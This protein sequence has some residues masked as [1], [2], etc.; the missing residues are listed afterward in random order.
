MT[1][2]SAEGTRTR[3]LGR[4]V[5]HHQLAIGGM[6]AVYLGKLLGPAGFSRAVAIK[7]LHPHLAH[8]PQFSQMLLDEARIAARIR[9][10]NVVPTLDVV[11]EGGE[12]FIVM[13][14]VH[15]E[16]LGKILRTLQDRGE[17][18]VA[19]AIASAIVS[20][21]LAGLHA[22]H[23]ATTEDMRPL[24]V[25]HRDVS[26]PNVLIGS[27]GIARTVDF[28]IAVALG[29]LQ[30]TKEGQLKGKLPY[31]APEQLRGE[32]VD[33]RADLWATACVLY[34]LLA[35]RRLFEGEDAS[36]VFKILH[37]QYRSPFEG[38]S[39]SNGALELVLQ[40]ALSVDRTERYDT[41]SSMLAAL[42]MACPPA[43]AN[44]V[45]R[46]LD[47]VLGHSL[48]QQRV[49][50]SEVETSTF[51]AP[52][53]SA[54]RPAKR[55]SR[56]LWLV[57]AGVAALAG[58]GAG[59]WVQARRAPDDAVAAAGRSVDGPQASALQAEDAPRGLAA[60]GPQPAPLVE[61]P[62]SGAMASVASVAAPPTS[63][64]SAS[65]PR[66]ERSSR[67]A[68]A[69]ASTPASLPTQTTTR[70]GN[71]TSAVPSGGGI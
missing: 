24:G 34:E 31:M 26:P 54:L 39:V 59:V 15:G 30:V 16:S 57:P 44:Q 20:G 8:D 42:E 40:R 28:G 69:P 37:F 9:H 19:P 17:G 23:E 35:G 71:S 55:S 58:A 29:R 27:D 51:D 6:A 64:P 45:A 3:R 61:A 68:S 67:P 63:A 43:S 62:S 36:L 33:R 7:R 65:A 32:A 4:Y 2:P 10:P 41:A 11:S 52:P 70:V 13:E 14:F 56:A 60:P 49:L 21:M 47:G 25:V 50:L 12:L 46:W 66:P 38:T 18:R 22:A 48:N 53:L 5:L 1:T